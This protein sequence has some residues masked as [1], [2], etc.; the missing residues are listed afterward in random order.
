MP[1]RHP[2][3]CFFVRSGTVP[4]VSERQSETVSLR[5]L[6]SFECLAPDG[7]QIAIQ[8]PKQRGVLAYLALAHGKRAPRAALASLFWSTTGEGQ[9]RQSLRQCLS[10]LRKL[11]DVGQGAPLV[12]EGAEVGLD[13]AGVHVDVDEV[14][15]GM[16]RLEDACEASRHVR[17][18]LLPGL[19]FGEEDADDFLRDARVRLLDAGQRLL[20]RC[21]GQ[22]AGAGDDQELVE[23]YW[24]LL[25]LSPAC[26]EA[27]RGL[28]EVYARLGR[29]SEALS[30][31]QACEDALRRHLDASP[32]PETVA[33]YD[34]LR[35]GEKAQPEHAAPRAKTL[36][37]PDKPSIAVMPFENL[38]GDPTRSYLCDGFTEDITTALSQ[39][40]SLCVMSR[41]SAFALRG[42]KL[43]V[44]EI[45]RRLGVHHVLLGS[46]QFAGE[47]IR[48]TT[49][50]ADAEHGAQIWSQ[51]NDTVLSDVFD[52]Q[53]ELVQ[54]VV[55]TVAGRV[56]AA[57][58]ARAR[59]K[60]TTALEAY[61]CVLRGRYHHHLYTPEDSDK[62]IEFFQAAIK[63]KPDY[64][65][66][67]GW[68]AC[69]IGRAMNFKQSRADRMHSKR[70]MKLID[71]HFKALKASE[72]VD[73][74][75][76]ECLRLI[77]E[78]HLFG[79]RFD[80]AEYYLRRAYALN[81]NDD[82]IQSQMAALL[83]F[84]G[85]LEEAERFARRAIRSNPF[86]PSFYQFNLGRVLLLQ[87]RYAEAAEALRMATPTQNR[88]RCYLAACYVALG[89]LDAA[90]EVRQAIYGEEPEFSLEHFAITFLYRDPA[91]GAQLRKLMQ[92]AGLA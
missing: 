48:V 89:Q 80:E 90:A 84:L 81:P 11:L 65:L 79:R 78:L 55:A 46:V 82:R 54:R 17:G 77:G 13:P 42:E 57:A 73:D 31:Y 69:A 68:L 66:A 51:R 50:L 26:E 30:Q 20:L 49:E 59:R 86:H 37:L 21:A 45:G 75:E 47:R 44:P 5:L 43:T 56:E 76:T 63:Q 7:S 8:A 61:D 36:P 12:S 38:S 72:L 62:A 41:S 23:T 4:R 40:S 58:L 87:Q 28:M 71:D 88:Y 1:R 25:G 74:E 83:C 22:Q 10:S 24:R 18:P 16:S 3:S 15:G 33:L 70:Y 67:Q 60:A 85:D 64:T 29:R 9:A 91:V 39:F 19:I 32:A 6:G 14:L 53:D 35:A 34:R 92:Q 27:H 2:S 52:F